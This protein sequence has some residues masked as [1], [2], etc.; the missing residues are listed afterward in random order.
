VQVA[1]LLSRNQLSALISSLQS[2]IQGAETARLHDEPLNFFDY[3]VSAAAEITRDPGLY[4]LN[5]GASKLVE[6]GVLN[7]FL[8]GLP[9]TSEIMNI[10]EKDWEAMGNIQQIEFIEDLKSKIGVYQ[11]YYIDVNNWTKFDSENEGDSLYRV[12]LTMLP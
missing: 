12:P 4:A 8:E 6:T 5:P 7:E 10:T 3:V 2:V 11:G 1:V 9:Y